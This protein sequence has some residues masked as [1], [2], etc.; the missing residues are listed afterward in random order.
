LRF[1]DINLHH[2]SV[3]KVSK[4]TGIYIALYP[5]RTKNDTHQSN[6]E[7]LVD[8]TFHNYSLQQLSTQDEYSDISITELHQ[9]AGAESAYFAQII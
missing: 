4:V 3:S 9:E 7:T 2:S 6:I 5:Y 8:N 1:A